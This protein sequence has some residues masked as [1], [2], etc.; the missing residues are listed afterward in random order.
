MIHAACGDGDEVIIGEVIK[1]GDA[2]AC[3]DGD[4]Q[5][6]GFAEKE[7]DDGL[8]VL[9]LWE[10]AM[11]GLSNEFDASTFEPLI[12]IAMIKLLKKTFQ[13]AVT[14]RINALQ[15]ADILKRVGT[16]TASATRNLNFGKY[17]VRGLKDGN[18]HLRA[19]FLEIDGQEE[20]GCTSTY[21]C[22]LHSSL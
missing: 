6:T 5:A 1:V 8:R 20:S 21:D 18:V 3:L 11:I 14:S 22:C 17:V 16:V 13:Q 10:D 19:H 12:G 9:R 7:V 2:T 15:V 4:A